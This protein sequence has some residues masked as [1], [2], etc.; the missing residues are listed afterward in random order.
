MSAGRGRE[1]AVDG[2]AESDGAS[3]II[4]VSSSLGA[5]VGGR[6][7]RLREPDIENDD[8]DDSDDVDGDINAGVEAAEGLGSGDGDKLDDSLLLSL[9]ILLLDS[10]ICALSRG[11]ATALGFGL[12]R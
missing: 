11:L 6:E 1:D 2:L 10:D 4:G 5:E 3:G 12:P 7:R 9:L 8:L